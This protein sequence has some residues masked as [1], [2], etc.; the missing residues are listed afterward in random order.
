MQ[1]S[2]TIQEMELAMKRFFILA[3]FVGFAVS[4]QAGN[5]KFTCKNADGSILITRDKLVLLQKDV[6]FE[7]TDLVVLNNLTNN[8]MPT[9]EEVIQFESENNDGKKVGD[10]KISTILNRKQIAGNDGETCEGGHGPGFSTETYKAR[11][12]L[13]V[14]GNKAKTVELSC[15]ESYYWAGNCVFDG[16]Q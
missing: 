2:S 3:M 10:L 14:F 12:Q 1:L 7:Q 16:E 6:Y 4:A 8:I 11:G 15:V 9:T 5:M 13:S